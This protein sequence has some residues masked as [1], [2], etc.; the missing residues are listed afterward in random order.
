M[1]IQDLIA[2]LLMPG[3][4]PMPSQEESGQRAMEDLNRNDAVEKIDDWISGPPQTKWNCS[5]DEYAARLRNLVKKP[6]LL[7]QGR[8]PWCMYAA[9]LYL[10]LTRNAAAVAQYALDLY[11]HRGDAK[12]GNFKAKIDDDLL[13]FDVV[14]YGQRLL[15]EKPKNNQQFTT[16]HRT[17]WILLAGLC[18]GTV[19]KDPIIGFDTYFEGPLEEAEEK[20]D[21]PETMETIL[22][23][24]LEYSG[25]VTVTEINASMSDPEVQN[26]ITPAW[27]C[28]VILIAPYP[29]Y[30]LA[31]ALTG[32][33]FSVLGGRHAAPVVSIGGG[34]LTFWSWGQAA[35]AARLQQIQGQGRIVSVDPVTGNCQVGLAFDILKGPLIRGGKRVVIRAKL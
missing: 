29:R 18:A 12:L 7:E 35:V 2:L 11:D 4:P 8:Y 32:S 24:S 16:D 31:D 30:F 9:C 14:K 27:N 22:N 25:G 21:D 3:Q 10:L 26:L 17:D 19:Y 15:D 34:N 28:D 20:A 13:N 5:P 33:D 23:K 1:G 6:Y